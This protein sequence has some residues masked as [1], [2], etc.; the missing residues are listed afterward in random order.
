MGRTDDLD[1]FFGPFILVVVI[2]ALL[3]VIVGAITLGYGLPSSTFSDTVSDVTSDS[4]STNESTES[5]LSTNTTD[6][7]KGT[8]GDQD[9]LQETVPG[10]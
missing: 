9:T 7:D 2:V 3:F 8:A 6:E 1:R 10:E 5:N 4:T